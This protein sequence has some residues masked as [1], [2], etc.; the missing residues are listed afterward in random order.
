MTQHLQSLLWILYYVGRL[1]QY[2]WVLQMNK[3]IHTLQECNTHSNRPLLWVVAPHKNHIPKTHNS[4]EGSDIH[5][6]LH[7]GVG[8][9]CPLWYSRLVYMLR[10]PLNVNIH[11][12]VRRMGHVT[13]LKWLYCHLGLLHHL[14]HM[15]NPCRKWFQA[16]SLA[17]HATIYSMYTHTLVTTDHI[18]KK[19]FSS[20]TLHH[21]VGHTTTGSYQRQVIIHVSSGW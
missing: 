3:Q 17:L 14:D 4:Q 13:I 6:W 12:C 10:W 16:H 5:A 19:P 9:H 20:N 15:I 1:T 11:E 21:T 2:H 7:P 18:N 8:N